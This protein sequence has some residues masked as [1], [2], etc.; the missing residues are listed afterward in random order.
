MLGRLLRYLLSWSVT[1]IVLMGTVSVL[2][3]QEKA[4]EGSIASGAGPAAT[5]T[6]LSL[7]KQGPDRCSDE[8]LCESQMVIK[9]EGRESYRGPLFIEDLPPQGFQLVEF[10]PNTRWI[11]LQDSHLIDC[12]DPEFSL[13]PDQSVTITILT[14]KPLGD[15][16]ESAATI[17]NCAQLRWPLGDTSAPE[18]IARSVQIALALYGY[19]PGQT[20]GS[21]STETEKAIGSYQ[22]DHGM[23]ET[24][25]I[26]LDFLNAIFGSSETSRGDANGD[27]DRSCFQQSLPGT[28][29]SGGGHTRESTHRR[30]DSPI[31]T[32]RETHYRSDSYRHDRG[33]THYRFGSYHSPWMSHNRNY[34]GHTNYQSHFSQSSGHGSSLSHYRYASVHFGTDSHRYRDSHAKPG[35]VHRYPQSHYYPRSHSARAS[36][37]PRASHSYRDS[38]GKPGSVHRYPQSHYFPKSHT[39]RAS[40]NPRASHGYRDSHG[41]PG[42]VHRYPQSHF[43][44]KSHNPRASHNPRKSHSS[45]LSHNPRKSHGSKM[46]H[47]RRLSHNRI[48]SSGGGGGGAAGKCR[49][50]GGIWVH[51]P[52]RSRM[53]CK[54]Y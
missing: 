13:E 25:K 9:N 20:D 43:Y 26:D 10:Q 40:H 5:L 7:V 48:K 47:N 32:R 49:R 30:Y 6:D 35:S 2:H 23:K 52:G 8:L 14:Q 50:A 19:N 12:V 17:E 16:A 15:V 31:H 21:L 34:S 28:T 27:N 1:G 18:A 53:G 51:I 41:K 46:S 36:H 33:L 4:S 54:V 11:C 3:G 38:H 37:N 24:G 42:S 29:I 44:P 22:K 45:R 39:A